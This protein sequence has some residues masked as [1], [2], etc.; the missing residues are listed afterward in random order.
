MED[1]D[2]ILAKLEGL[3][4]VFR[5]ISLHVGKQYDPVF[6]GIEISNV[7][8]QCNAELDDFDIQ[9]LKDKSVDCKEV[10]SF[11]LCIRNFKHHVTTPTESSLQIQ[12]S[13]R[14]SEPSQASE[15]SPRKRPCMQIT[16]QLI[17]EN[18]QAFNMYVTNKLTRPEK[19]S[20]EC[21]NS[22]KSLY[23]VS[24]DPSIPFKMMTEK[25]AHSI[26]LSSATISPLSHMKKELGLF[27]AKEFTG[28]CIVED[29]QV[30]FFFFY[31]CVWG[32]LSQMLKQF[33]CNVLKL[34]SLQIFARI[35]KCGAG[36]QFFELKNS[37][38]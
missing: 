4:R 16:S 38:W 20:S 35:V 34:A 18:V 7:F 25:N 32:Y 36:G 37:H 22:C 9:Y 2:K 5:S 21:E 24:L 10:L 6:K 15:Q 28:E 29:Y 3:K 1:A 13:P 8:R 12:Q 30:S 26:L 19:H 17:Q 31:Q 14:K 23:F 11:I 27:D 33:G